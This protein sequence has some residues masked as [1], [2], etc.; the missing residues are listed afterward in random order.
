MINVIF[1]SQLSHH[2]LFSLEKKVKF[3]FGRDRE[4]MKIHS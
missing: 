2:L 3:R 1:F 4:E